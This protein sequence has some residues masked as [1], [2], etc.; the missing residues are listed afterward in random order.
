M[1][2]RALIASTL[3]FNIYFNFSAAFAEPAF[4]EGEPAYA[5]Q[6]SQIEK[7]LPAFSELVKNISRSVV[8]I[9]SESGEE[10]EQKDQETEAEEDTEREPGQPETPFFKNPHAQRSLGSGFIIGADGYIITNYHVVQNAQEIKVRMVDERTDYSAELIGSDE[11]T[12]LALIKI[13]PKEKLPV[14]YLGDSDTL[15]VGEWVL[16]VGNQFQLGQSVTAGI[17]SAKARRVPNQISGPYDQFIQTDAAIN[18]GS[19]GGPLVNTHGQ[20]VGINT[21]IFSPGRQQFGGTGFNIGI[22]F[23]IPVNLAK[24]IISQLKEQGKVIRGLLGVIIQPVDQDVAQALNMEKIRGALVSDVIAGSPAEKAGFKRRDVIIEFNSQP[25][26]DHDDL[27]LMVANTPIGTTVAVKAIREGKE[28]SL[29]PRIDELTRASFERPKQ[30]IED[31]DKLGMIVSEVPE[32]I[33]KALQQSS[34]EGVLVRKVIPDSR[35]AESGF[36]PGDIIEEMAGRPIQD[37][38]SY[39]TILKSLKDDR[40]L[41]VLVRRKQGT[42]Y[43]VLK[44]Q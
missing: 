34:P 26:D 37:R 39:Q 35:A 3:L 20:V 41:L 11:K 31:P 25:V 15:E 9:S 19:S 42:R 32:E 7:Q 23:A 44:K 22:G 21:A 24:G 40:P 28:I 6:A 30:E 43:L 16:A 8:N 18:P 27:P 33:S 36:V 12:D 5:F 10:S 1:T 4:L 29:Q 17:V 14:L 2:R 13:E 38:A